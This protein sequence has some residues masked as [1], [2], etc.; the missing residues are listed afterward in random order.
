M[1][2]GLGL[3]LCEIA[4]LRAALARGGE[5]LT[6]RLFTEA[7]QEYAGRHR[8]PAPSFAARF[9]AKEAFVKALG[10]WPAGMRWTDVEVRS[11]AHGRPELLL[12]GAALLALEGRQAHLS[13]THERGMA[14][15]VVVLETY[16]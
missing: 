7:E 2:A 15:A 11:G 10:G 16:S 5:R 9:A 13:L 8:D 12:H 1:I 3:D 6:S 14:G 4:R